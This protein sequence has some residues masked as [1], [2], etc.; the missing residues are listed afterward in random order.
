MQHDPSGWR[1]RLDPDM[2][3]RYR[4][5]GAWLDRTIGAQ[6]RALA[7]TPSGKVRKC[8]SGANGGS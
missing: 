3:A 8:F 7:M 2:I 4:T 6:L 1:T 5:Q